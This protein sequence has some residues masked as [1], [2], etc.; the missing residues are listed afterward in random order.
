VETSDSSTYRIQTVFGETVGAFQY[1]ASGDFYLSKFPSAR[2]DVP[3]HQE[4]AEN[5]PYENTSLYFNL[6]YQL[7]DHSQANL[8]FSFIDGKNEIDGPE[9]DND[10]SIAF[11]RQETLALNYQSD[12]YDERWQMGLFA[13]YSKVKRKERQDFTITPSYPYTD[14]HLSGESLLL[15]CHHR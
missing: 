13:S 10:T 2:T 9:L 4:N 1:A 11:F 5:D 15:E 6:G 14:D 12:R 8:D 7:D 3:I